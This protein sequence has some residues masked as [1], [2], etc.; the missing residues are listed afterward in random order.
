MF[1]T[2]Y[3]LLDPTDTVVADGTAEQGTYR[4]TRTLYGFQVT[5]DGVEIYTS[6]E[7]CINYATDEVAISADS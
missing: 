4:F 3:Q 7:V 5:R 6:P 2:G 1:G